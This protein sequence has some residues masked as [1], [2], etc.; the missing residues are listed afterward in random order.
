M[1]VRSI[2]ELIFIHVLWLVNKC[3]ICSFGIL[4][5][6][7]QPVYK[8]ERE[9]LESIVTFWSN[10]KA[11]L[12]YWCSCRHKRCYLVYDYLYLVLYLR[13]E[14]ELHFLAPELWAQV[15][16]LIYL[17]SLCLSV[18]FFLNFHI[19]IFLW[20]TTRTI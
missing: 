11:C 20:R 19:F 8:T 1:L 12:L 16:F 9:L 13:T 15:S 4:F 3:T 6:S 5:N 2:N 18:F 10:C 14:G 7:A 17:S